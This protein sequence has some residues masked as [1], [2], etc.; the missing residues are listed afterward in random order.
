MAKRRVRFGSSS[1]TPSLIKAL[2]GL[3]LS[4]V[5]G[6][7]SVWA[8]TYFLSPAGDDSSTGLEQRSPWKTFRFAIPRLQ[9]GDTLML[10]DGTYTPSNSGFPSF[11]GINGTATKPITLKALNE[12]KAHIQNDGTAISVTGATC[13]YLVLDGIQASSQDN[14][15]S[16]TT[17]GAVEF[18]DCH[19]LTL[20]RLL[21]HHNNRYANSHLLTFLRVTDS[22]VEETEFYYFHRHGV[23]TKPGS[24]NIFRRLYCHSRGYGNITGGFP[25]GHG[26][27]GGDVCVSLYPGDNSI[28]ENTIADATTGSVFDIQ[29][30]GPTPGDNNRFLG[31]IA[32][33]T[34]YGAVIKARPQPGPTALAMPKNNIIENFVAIGVQAVGVYLRGVRGQRC[35][36]CMIL[37]SSKGSGLVVDTEKDSLGDGVYSVFLE[38]SLTLSNDGM[39]FLIQPEIQTFTLSSVNSFGNRQNYYPLSSRGYVNSKSVDS[40]LG[41]CRVWIPDT[42][43]MKKTGTNDKDI[44]ANILYRYENGTLTKVPLWDRSTGEFPYGAI[45][46]GVNDIA[47]QSLFDVHKRLN[48]NANGCSF[49]ANYGSDRSSDEAAPARPVGLQAS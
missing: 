28:I 43:P 24:R 7:E 17:G 22:L 18:R 31:N 1:V 36:H 8:A 46:D 26:I 16:K 23:M 34:Q 32:L 48:V 40:S 21:L 33:N 2:G 45:V 47:G 14:S 27:A 6:F 5:V 30:S 13:S 44:G 42:S 10:L 35:D 12:R 15:D 19:H 25:N 49:P 20:K 38:N 11:R 41:A 29:A 39:G 3:I 9:P 4:I 37:N